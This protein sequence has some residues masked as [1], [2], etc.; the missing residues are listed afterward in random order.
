MIEY[1]TIIP[2]RKNSKRVKRKNIT[3]VK[4]KE[5][6]TYTFKHAIGSNY[7]K[8]IIVSTDDEKIIKLTKKYKLQFLIRPKNYL[9]QMRQQKV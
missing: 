6:I 4:K 7:K 5:L 8:N 9:G 3:L 1:L 2:A